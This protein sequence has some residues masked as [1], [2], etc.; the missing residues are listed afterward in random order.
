LSNTKPAPKAAVSSDAAPGTFNTVLVGVD[1]TSTGRDAIA[2]GATLRAHGGRLI[3]AHVVL[4]Q[5]PICCT[6]HSTS[7]G[8][9]SRA[10][11]ER[12]RTAEGATAGL[13]GLFAPSIRS[14]LHDLAEDVE[15]DLLVVG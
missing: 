2:L 12:E 13:T 3:L 7:I 10:M 6:F 14:G 1:G 11:L 15:A 4:A 5:V 9:N 8:R